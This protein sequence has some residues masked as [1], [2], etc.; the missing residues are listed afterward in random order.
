[1]NTT[2]HHPDEREWQL[3]ERALHDERLGVGES[4]DPALARYRQVARV[5]R[6]PLPS[7]LPADFA[8][9]VIARV[10]SL[11]APADMRL[12]QALTGGLMVLLAMAA[13]AAFWLYGGD[14]L[15]ESLA[16]LPRQATGF[17]L[18][19]GVALA[20]CIGLSWS[21]EQLRRHR[22]MHPHD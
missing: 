17:A 4:E 9:R 22:G 13:V 10:G 5:L 8:T 11:H 6:Q 18:N 12:E 19:W 1:M 20:A 14:W 7:A 15:R 21:L 2:P 16:L 3:Q